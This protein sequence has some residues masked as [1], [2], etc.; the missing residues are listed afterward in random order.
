MN[1]SLLLS[2]FFQKGSRYQF[3]EIYAISDLISRF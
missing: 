2:H 3:N 1:I